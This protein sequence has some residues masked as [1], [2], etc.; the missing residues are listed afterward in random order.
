[1][2]VVRMGIDANVHKNKGKYKAIAKFTIRALFYYSDT[3]RM[4][5]NFN[6][7]ERKLLF[8]KQPNFLSKFVTPYLCNGF[9]KKQKIEILSKHYDWFENTFKTPARHNIYNERINLLEL[10]IGEQTYLLNLSFERNS[11]KEGELTLSLTDSQLNK[12]YTLSFSVFNNDIYI[13]GV[14]GAANDNGFSRAFTKA[15]HG[16]RPKSFIVETLR[17]MAS[18]LGITHIYAVNEASHVSNSFRYGKKSKDINLKYDELWEEHN[19]AQHNKCFYVLPLRATRKDLEPLKRQ[20]RK[21]YR[22]R[23]A[24]LDQYEEDLRAAI[25]PHLQAPITLNVDL[26]KAS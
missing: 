7:D 2:N 4:N 24:W 17:L 12:M 5:E 26:A 6:S 9:S 23:Y 19:G 22:Q 16:L 8:K 1:M 25:N 21:L 11:R 13:G 10:E 20:K 14:Q 3:K 15:L 18:D